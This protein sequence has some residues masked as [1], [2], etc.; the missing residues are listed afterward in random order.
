MAN[1]L[2][3]GIDY[4]DITSLFTG[5]VSGAY[6]KTGGTAS[7]SVFVRAAA[8]DVSEYVGRNVK[9]T[10]VAYTT[11]SGGSSGYGI[12]FKDAN[13]GLLEAWA[14]PK[15]GSTPGS[16]RTYWVD[17]VIPAD[18][19]TMLVTYLGEAKLTEIGG[20]SFGVFVENAES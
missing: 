18:A 16:A 12:V 5:W 9:Y 10:F 3:L 19:K 20:D 13:G 17:G 14:F 11:G 6:T 8:V 7:S 1:A 15:D 4:T 2:E